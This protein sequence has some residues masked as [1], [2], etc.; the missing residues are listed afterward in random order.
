MDHRPRVNQSQDKLHLFLLPVPSSNYEGLS[1][2]EM[3]T[4][5]LN[6]I[7]KKRP[8]LRH[9]PFPIQYMADSAGN[10][11]AALTA[12]SACYLAS[13]QQSRSI[14]I[15][16][17]QLCCACDQRTYVQP[18]KGTFFNLFSLTSHQT[19]THKRCFKSINIQI[20]AYTGS[21]QSPLVG[22]SG[23]LALRFSSRDD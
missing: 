22:A 8:A 21:V 18:R 9:T 2:P 13:L 10:S 3:H 12:R 6:N 14:V 11:N 23:R 19:F 5:G 4:H 17:N 15:E 7:C 1:Y 20:D 16:T